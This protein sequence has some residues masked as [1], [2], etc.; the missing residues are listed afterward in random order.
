M[1]KK[2]YCNLKWDM[3]GINLS[4]QSI[5]QCCRTD[6]LQYDLKE[7]ERDVINVFNAE[8]LVK[9]RQEV[10]D[11]KVPSSCK[12][13]VE[14]EDKGIYIQ[15]D[16]LN[17]REDRIYETP[18]QSQLPPRI[19]FALHNFCNLTCVYCG[20]IFSSSWTKDIKEN[21]EYE[22]KTISIKDIVRNKVSLSDY[23]S[24]SSFNIL[25]QITQHP[26]F[27]TVKTIT[28]LGGE[29]LI[30]PF[31]TD[32]VKDILDNNS[33]VEL[34]I[35]TGLGIPEKRFLSTIEQLQQIDQR[36]QLRINVSV[37]TTGKTFE[38]IRHGITWDDF[39][40]RFEHLVGQFTPKRMSI[41]TTVFILAVFDYKN[42]L[43]Y[44]KELGFDTKQ[45]Q[46]G[47][48]QDPKYLS[49]LS[50][51]AQ[52]TGPY[53]QDLLDSGLLGEDL[54]RTLKA[55]QEQQKSNQELHR[56]FITYI[57]DFAQRRALDINIFP[58][59]LINE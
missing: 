43:E 6:W 29:P 23:N 58:R 28:L 17:S 19:D 4:D 8:H 36:K 10:L 45:V 13:C 34:W 46:F 7:S 26:D 38:F 33:T 41:L 44:I 21:G 48:L 51:D 22:T 35:T 24:S 37:E 40:R 27:P 1:D 5:A 56:Q 20:P 42:L 57:K 11:G 12:N 15:N 9:E 16:L 54:T 25:R 2:F 18:N 47:Y 55:T 49:L 50:F 53:I 14:Y 3:A 39:Q 32:V 31:I 59:E 52:V 30:N